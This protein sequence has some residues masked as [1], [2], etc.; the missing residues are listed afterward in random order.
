MNR[1]TVLSLFCLVLLTA[2]VAGTSKAQDFEYWP[3]TQYD[4]SVPTAMEILGYH[5]GDRIT[6]HAGLMKYLEA[7]ESA[8]PGQVRILEYAR[9]WEG[10]KLVYAFVGSPERIGALE[11]VSDGM[12]RLADPRI[13]SRASAD[14]LIAS[15]PAIVNLSYSVHGNEISPGDAALFTA[16]HLLAARNDPV[17]DRILEE[18]IVMIDP[19]QNPD[20]RDRFVHNFEIAEGLEP[21][22]SPLAA[23]HNEPWPGGRTNHY[24]FDLNRDWISLN[25]PETL[26]RV[27]VLQDYFPPVFVDLHEMGSNTTYYFAPEAV[28]YNPHLARDQ[29]ESLQLFGRNNAKWFDHYGF[30]YFT[31]EIFDAFYPGYGASW[32]SY[33]GSVA[34][35]YEQASARGLVVR[36]SDASVMHFRDTVR[37]HFVASIA[38]SETAAINREKLLEDFYAYRESAIRE[39]R[40]ENIKS[41]VLPRRPDGNTSGVDKLAWLMAYHGVEVHQTGSDFRSG[42]ETYPAGSYVISLAQPAKRLVRTLMDV[43]VPMSDDFIEEQER[44]R[45]KGMGDQIYDVTAWSFPLMYNVEAVAVDRAVEGDLTLVDPVMIPPGSIDGG[46]AKVAYLVPWGTQAAGRLLAASLRAGLRAFSTDLPFVQGDRRYPS[47]TLIFKVKENPD[48]LHD[49]L[50]GIAATSGAEVIATDTGWVDEGPNFG[51][52]NVVFMRAPRI[53]LAWDRPTRAYNAGATR[54]VVERQ[55]GYPVTVIRTRQLAFAELRDFDVLL[56]PDPGFGASYGDALGDRG[57]RRIRDWVRAGGTVVGLGAGAT[58]YLAAETTGLLSTT[59]EDEADGESDSG[60]D[61]SG[62]GGASG[63]IF[64]TEDEYLQALNPDDSAPPSTQGVLLRAG[65]DPD[66]WLAAGRDETVHAL[67]SGSSIFAPLKLDEGSN[68]AVYLGP[69]EV[70]ASGFAWEG[71]TMQ[72]AYKPLLMAQRNGRGL[73]IGFTADPNFRAYMDGLNILFMNAIFRGPAHAGAAVTE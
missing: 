34:M 72:L 29:R 68:V 36:R 46:R 61:D 27:K 39:G 18:T 44:R 59:R 60:N 23:E 14:S 62:N 65:L 51:S 57:T 10:R 30:S 28:P 9:S 2:I 6:S 25:H 64:E 4:A 56:L 1:Y 16:Y 13:T 17:V 71:S 50:A 37:H 73:A 42:G 58:A 55:I 45:S 3:G 11:D 49:T 52:N 20:G 26:G 53:A 41:Y 47:G 19:V 12:K 7:L 15:L 22:A 24:Y 21:N 67:V 8:L 40:S 33:Y 38:T 54:F 66:H 32:P 69:E 43:H 70:L 63:R 5:I 48:H 35:T 31:R